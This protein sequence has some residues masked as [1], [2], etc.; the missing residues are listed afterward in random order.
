MYLQ[1][2]TRL[3]EYNYSLSSLGLFELALKDE[4]YLQNE[5]LSARLKDINIFG[6]SIR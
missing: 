2:A 6:L 3:S 5:A 1:N 4:F